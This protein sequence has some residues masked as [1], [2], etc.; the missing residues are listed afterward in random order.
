[1][2]G[3]SRFRWRVA[4]VSLA[5]ALALLAAGELGLHLLVAARLGWRCEW[6]AHAGA[7][8]AADECAGEPEGATRVLAAAGPRLRCGGGAWSFSRYVRRAHARAPAPQCGQ[9]GDAAPLRR[10]GAALVSHAHPRPVSSETL[11]RCLFGRRLRRNAHASLALASAAAAAQP[12][13]IVLAG[14]VFEDALVA[15][16]GEW[17][18]CV[19]AWGRLEA[20]LRHAAPG[21]ALV[22]APGDRDFPQG[23][24]GGLRSLEA[25]FR[26]LADSC[27]GT[28]LLGGT[29]VTIAEL[30]GDSLEGALR[31][32]RADIL[33]SHL[34]FPRP[35][36]ESDSDACAGG[37]DM[38]VCRG[39]Q[40]RGG[41]EFGA[42]EHDDASAGGYDG[43]CKASA[44]AASQAQ[45]REDTLEPAL[46][47]AAVRAAAPLATLSAHSGRFC[48][49]SEGSTLHVELPALSLRQR[50]DPAVVLLSVGE[51]EARAQLC[52][53]PTETDALKFAALALGAVTIGSLVLSV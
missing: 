35:G 8:Q 23:S 41:K 21:A 44:S 38:P 53:L 52:A 46:G 48:A 34:P 13:A 11:T 33:V 24:S 3:S 30:R 16:A 10:C 31:V 29:N 17:D 42:A 49:R 6:P 15:R 20:L 9:P 12:R 5:A 50:D 1:M 36:W 7:Q 51:G 14:D 43:F 32:G 22:V 45:R 19:A 39:F 4:C 18:S 28:E 2:A 25:R 47:R 27:A 26:G 40:S 37:A